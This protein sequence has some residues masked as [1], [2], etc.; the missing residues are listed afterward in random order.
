[1]KLVQH[2]RGCLPENLY[3]PLD[4]APLI[5]VPSTIW[6]IRNSRTDCMETHQPVL[7]PRSTVTE[8]QDAG[9]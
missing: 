3:L 9:Y 1:M 6:T 5:T 7:R 4:L 2:F 8:Q